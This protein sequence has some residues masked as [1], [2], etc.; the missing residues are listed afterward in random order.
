MSLR[1]VGAARPVP[2]LL[3]AWFRVGVGLPVPLAV[4]VCLRWLFGC[5]RWR[6][7]YAAVG[8]RPFAALP[9]RKR[10][11]APGL[12]ARHGV[13]VPAARASGGGLSGSV[14]G[15]RAGVPLRCCLLSCWD[16]ARFACS[17]NDVACIDVP[18]C[19]WARKVLGPCSCVRIRAP[20][21]CSALVPGGWW[22]SWDARHWHVPLLWRGGAVWRD[23]AGAL[24]CSLSGHC[25]CTAK[26]K[27]RYYILQ[28]YPPSYLSV[29]NSGL[30]AELCES[31]TEDCRPRGVHARMYMHRHYH[32]I[33]TQ[34][35]NV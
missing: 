20:A 31:R 9:P 8:G 23:G 33:C 10:V 24:A 3:P 34:E 16:W 35:S 25:G 32:V 12:A 11:C 6:A 7:W 5:S 21:R 1:W 4:R 14:R 22:G 13:P 27:Y 30:R 2:A 28:T 19:V 15:A 17:G 18:L 29:Y 26:S